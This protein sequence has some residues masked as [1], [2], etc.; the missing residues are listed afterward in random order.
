VK[1]RAMSVES[2]K[3]IVTFPDGDLDEERDAKT[4]LYNGYSVFGYTDDGKLMLQND[5]LYYSGN[6]Y[7]KID[8]VE[9]NN[10][11]VSI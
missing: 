3:G 1:L 6:I 8:N 7:N 10:P 11:R 4:L 2:N 9:K 5:I